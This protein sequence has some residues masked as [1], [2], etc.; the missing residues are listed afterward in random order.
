MRQGG[1]KWKEK[2]AGKLE[3]KCR[4]KKQPLSE[5]RWPVLGHVTLSERGKAFY[6]IA[7]ILDVNYYAVRTRDRLQI[8]YRS[9]WLKKRKSKQKAFSPSFLSKI[10]CHESSLEIMIRATSQAEP[11]GT[12]IAKFVRIQNRIDNRRL[13]Q[14][15]N[16]SSSERTVHLTH[17]SI[18]ASNHPWRWI[19]DGVGKKHLI[20]GSSTT[21]GSRGPGSDWW[22]FWWFQGAVWDRGR[23]LMAP[24]CVLGFLFS[25]LL[26]DVVR[27]S[28]S[29]GM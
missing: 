8:R 5:T 2:L 29:N 21:A 3:I 27:C 14:T 28:D 4:A 10:N 22:W 26:I 20:E 1:R 19:G 9:E 12:N 16:V 17:G 18:T 23:G 13:W 11:I 25:V 15:L 6:N 24:S 7:M